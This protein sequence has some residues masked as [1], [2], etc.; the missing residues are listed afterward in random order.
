MP[1]ATAEALARILAPRITA[2]RQAA[3]AL[4]ELMARTW[5]ATPVAS[6]PPSA[7]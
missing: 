5:V 7:A 3:A 4:F 6:S 1:D 2:R